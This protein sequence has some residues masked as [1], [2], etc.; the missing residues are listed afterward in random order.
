MFFIGSLIGIIAGVISLIA[1]LQ[2]K[3]GRISR[4]LLLVGSGILFFF[5]MVMFFQFFAIIDAG[6]VG[7]Q[8]RFGAVL[9]DILGE[10]FNIKDP[11]ADVYTYNIRLR[12]HTLYGDDAIQ[13]RTKDNSLATIDCTILW[14]DD[15]EMAKD[16]YRKVAQDD[17]TLLDLII[18]PVVRNA[19]YDVAAKYNLDAI[20]Q[21]RDEFGLDVLNRVQELVKNKYVIVDSVLIRRITPPPRIDEAIQ[22]KLQAQQELEQKQFELEKAIKDAEIRRVEA[23]GIADA[24]EI[25]QKK[26]TQLYLQYEAIQTYKEL[27]ESQ[28]TTFIIMPT[29][30]EGV[31]IPLIIGQ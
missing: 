12:E 19:L 30:P 16:I 7:V 27:A 26:L 20:M 25:I 5:L 29:S 4:N 28:N 14:A 23:Q 13:A 31:G 10:G 15:P 6:E 3:L 24:Q 11:F 9:P 21:K 2:K 22:K 17:E 1:G 18:R 8:V